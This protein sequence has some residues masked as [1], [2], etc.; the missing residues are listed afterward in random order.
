[1]RLANAK[2][3]WWLMLV[4]SHCPFLR[5]RNWKGSCYEHLTW[6]AEALN[7]A[8]TMGLQLI[9]WLARLKLEFEQRKTP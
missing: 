5:W 7:R 8:W 9:D 6:Q 3:M 1:M 2:L 4:V